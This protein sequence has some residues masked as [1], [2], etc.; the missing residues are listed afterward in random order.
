MKSYEYCE[1]CECCR[2]KRKTKPYTASA[3]GWKNM[4]YYQCP[5]CKSNAVGEAR[6]KERS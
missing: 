3:W 6:A 2:V 1:R 4:N 5:K